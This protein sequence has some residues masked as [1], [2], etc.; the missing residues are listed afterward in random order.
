M[1]LAPSLDEPLLPL[2]EPSGDD[3]QRIQSVNSRRILV[4]RMKMGTVMRRKRLDI[5]PND[6]TEE[7]CQL[8]HDFED[9][10][11]CLKCNAF[12]RARRP[13]RVIR[14]IRGYFSGS[15]SAFCNLPSAIKKAAPKGGL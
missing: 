15:R 14:E 3:F 9:T 4:I 2:R 5:H 13:I 7:S 11:L 6:D 1:Q 12:A 10:D 8:G